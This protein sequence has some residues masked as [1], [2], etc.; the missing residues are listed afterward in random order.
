MARLGECLWMLGYGWVQDGAMAAGLGLGEGRRRRDWVITR[1][2]GGDGERDG[3]GR[4]S[5]DSVACSLL[6]SPLGAAV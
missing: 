4:S 3:I 1:I 5:L 6:G 2:A